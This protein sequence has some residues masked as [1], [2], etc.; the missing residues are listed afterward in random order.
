MLYEINNY[1]LPIERLGNE[2]V[3]NHIIQSILEVFI[4]QVI[5]VGY[6]LLLALDQL[7]PIS[8]IIRYAFILLISFR[9]GL[10]HGIH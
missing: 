3:T 8:N 7:T 2:K 10:D 4:L 6:E 5:D 9:D 1:L